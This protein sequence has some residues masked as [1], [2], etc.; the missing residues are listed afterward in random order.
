M[1]LKAIN[2]SFLTWIRA[3]SAWTLEY[4][5]CISAVGKTPIKEGPKYDTK[6]LIMKLYSWSL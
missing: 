1:P 3:L 4:A 2:Q 6:N 5:D